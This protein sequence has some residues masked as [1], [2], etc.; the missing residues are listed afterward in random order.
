MEALSSHNFRPRASRVRV[1]PDS[2]LSAGAP[3]KISWCPGGELRAGM[4]AGVG[5][6]GVGVVGYVFVLDMALLTC[7]L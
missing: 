2:V 3:R 7:E 1:F 4:G 5:L 6:L